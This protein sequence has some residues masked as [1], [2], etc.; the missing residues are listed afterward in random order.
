MIIGIVNQKG[1]TGKTTTAVNLAAC[2]VELGKKVLL[3]DLDPQGCATDWLGSE[4][5]EKFYKALDGKED[6]PIVNTPWPGLDLTP[7]SE[8]NAL[9]SKDSRRLRNALQAVN[10]YDFVLV[11]APPHLGILTLNLYVASNAVIITAEPSYLALR[12]A[13]KLKRSIETVQN[14]MN[15]DLKVLGL[16]GCRFVNTT[17]AKNVLE[18]YR[19]EQLFGD[20]IFKTVIRQNVA[21]ME[22]PSFNQPIINYDG[23]SHGSQDYRALALEVLE[24]SK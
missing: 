2:L 11:D 4:L 8:E 9:I 6:L 22:A 19:N 18:L 24:R 14:S 12:G 23:K 5:S 10:G 13:V 7:A 17:H 15:P 21:L 20:V 1:G 3:V 16:L